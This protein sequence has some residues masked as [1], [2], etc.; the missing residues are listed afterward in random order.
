M[1]VSKD[2]RTNGVT[3]EGKFSSIKKG[4]VKNS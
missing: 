4:C 2:N 3:S 1:H